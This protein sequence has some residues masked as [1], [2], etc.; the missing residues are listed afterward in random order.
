MA[1]GPILD[2]LLD[3]RWYALTAAFVAYLL[4]T[5]IYRR[6][7][8][9]LA[10]VPGPFLPAVTKLYQSFYSYRFYLQIEKLHRQYGPI[11]RITPDE[12][13]I[14]DAQSYDQ[15]YYVGS[16]YSKSPN[17][18]NALC[19]PH[20]SF[21]T[22]SND[23]HRIKRAAMNPMF[24][25]QK[26]LDLESIVQEKANKVCRRMQA[27]IDSGEPV[28]LHHSFRAL[29]VDVASEYAF[30][31]CYDFLDRSD[32]GARFGEMARGIGPALWVFQQFPSFQS[33]ALKTPPW[34]APYLST[35]LGYV[36][37]LQMECVRQIEGV[38]EK[39]REKKDL[40]RQTIFTTLLTKDDKPEEYQVPTTWELKDEAYS[41]LVAAADTTGNAMTVAA[42]NVLYSQ[43]IYRKLVK[44]LTDAF[45]DP[46]SDHSFVVLE[47]L[48]YLVGNCG[49][50]SLWRVA[51]C[52][53]RLP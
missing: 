43:E 12:V 22:L 16:K 31:R 40:G 17:F 30:N 34:M 3:V 6:F 38:K 48:P 27:D 42:F 21:G 35:P 1:T 7:F 50:K 18:Y 19:A 32:I 46:S 24:S 47:K 41:V 52:N 20:S 51:D 2:Q 29:S 45:P 8:H 9:P 13:H 37:G 26:V 36:T 11:V 15:I 25:R 39:M 5:C 53:S 23:V 10:N 4:S 44:E 33:L 14:A 28:D 49:Q